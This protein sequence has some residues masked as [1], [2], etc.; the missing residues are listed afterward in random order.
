MTQIIP[1]I[2]STT[3]EEF[4]RDI[5]RFKDS[6]SFQE[7]WVH[8]DFMDNLFVPNQSIEP[9]V[10]SK[11]PIDLHKEAHPM[12][13]HPNSWIDKLIEAGF[14]RIIFHIEA[15]GDINGYVNEIKSK[16]VEVGLAINHDTSLE[17][18]TQFIGKI[19]VVLLMSIVPGFQGQPFIEDSLEKI[20]ETSRLRS[21][22]NS[23]FKIAVDGAV[24]DE[25]AKQLIEAGV[26]NLIVGSYLL[27]G[28]LDE[29]LERLWEKIQS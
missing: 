16:G 11:Y 3:E 24:S 14:E 2:L 19:D 15:E 25:N 9:A 12:V 10:V 22:T 27:K 1:A 6:P 8:I 20:K 17:K 5:Q 21:K 13:L 23:N 29:N 26:D 7:G 18:L 4:E 28:D